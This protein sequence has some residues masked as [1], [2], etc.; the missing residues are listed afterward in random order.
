MWRK[1]DM[2]MGNAVAENIGVYKVCT[3]GRLDGCRDLGD[4][5]AERRGF[6][7]AELGD[8]REV[9]SGLKVGE[10]CDLAHIRCR[11]TPQV[12]TPH[13]G[14]HQCIVHPLAGTKWTVCVNHPTNLHYEPMLRRIIDR[15]RANRPMPFDEYMEWC[16]YDPSDGFFS[17]GPIRTGRKGDFVTSPEVSWAFGV[18]VGEW[19][20]KTAPSSHAAL[21]EVGTGSGALLRQIEEIWT[22]DRDLVFAVERSASARRLVAE[23][24]DGVI[25]VETIDEIPAGIDA[26]I[27]ANEVLD[28]MPAGLAR[29]VAEGWVEIGVGVEGDELILVDIPARVEA[30]IWCD[31]TFPDIAEGAV[32]SVQMAV[33]TWIESVFDRFSKVSLCLIDYGGTAEEL[34]DREPGSVVR[35]YRGHQTGIDWLQQPGESDITVDMN[36][37]A[38]LDAIARSGHE[39]RVVSQRDFCTEY[40]LTD[41][42]DDAKEGE[43]IAASTGQVMAQ[44][45]ERSQRLDME[46]LIDP[47]GLGAFNVILVGPR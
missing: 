37:D 35:T 13:L 46:A 16:L 18:P 36:V 27:V 8:I 14:A 11:E 17:A 5:V 26:V 38:V 21:I 33:S 19:A 47:N 34:Q 30:Q 20:E 10:S 23:S 7:T 43:L 1:V 45:E 2:E 12:V 22:M 39:A 40:G 42:I 3:S 41:V 29:R 4:R 44:L 9:P 28:N 31:D 25:V 32:V 6:L 15:I 24:F